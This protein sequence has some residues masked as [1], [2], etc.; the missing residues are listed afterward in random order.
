[1]TAFDTLTYA[2]KLRESGFTE[3]QAEAQAEA[4]R[5]VVE[6]NLATKSDIELVRREIEQLRSETRGLEVSLRREIELLR[7][8]LKKDIESLRA[9]LKKDIESL[10]AELKGDIELVRAGVNASELRM[11][12]RLGGLIAAGVA[13]LVALQH[14]F[15]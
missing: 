9:E 3:R 12:V 10:R 8:E 6:A 4:L 11:T 15:K 5:A 1:M 2:K 14:I 7:A 13:L